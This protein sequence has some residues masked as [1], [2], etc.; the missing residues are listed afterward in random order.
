MMPFKGSYCSF[1]FE[2]DNGE[3]ASEFGKE[4]ILEPVYIVI[5]LHLLP[6]YQ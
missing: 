4:G 5:K 6:L 2:T 3:G 1:Y